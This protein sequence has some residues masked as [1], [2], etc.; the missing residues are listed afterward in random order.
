MLLTNPGL[1]EECLEQKSASTKPKKPG[2]SEEALFADEASTALS[3]T[4]RNQP[5][6]ASDVSPETGSE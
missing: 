4:V 1:I 5:S 6:S 2:H 3:C